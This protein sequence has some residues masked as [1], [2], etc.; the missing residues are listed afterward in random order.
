MPA[1]ESE[2]AGH[3]GEEDLHS[4]RVSQIGSQRL[5]RAEAGRVF[6]YVELRIPSCALSEHIL[7]L[8]LGVLLGVGAA[9]LAGGSAGG[10]SAEGLETGSPGHG[11]HLDRVDL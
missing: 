4:D 10:G 1:C 6:A 11:G 8:S 3:D 9:E 7:P 5:P 2:G